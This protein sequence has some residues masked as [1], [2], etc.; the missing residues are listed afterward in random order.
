[1]EQ[2]RF[3][4]IMLG[5]N[6]W[7]T[8]LLLD[9][10]AKLTAEQFNRRFEIGLGSLHDTLRHIIG[11]MLR[12]ADRIAARTVQPSIEKTHPALTVAELLAFLDQAD[13]E[14]RVV[15]E[16]TTVAGLWNDPI[17]FSLPEGPVYR[18]SRAAAMMHVLS[19]GTYHRAQVVHMRKR[20]GLP[21]LGLDLDPIEWECSQTGQIIG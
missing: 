6:T 14:L 4:E 1:M 16:V 15:A 7:A 9:D 18:F 12:W 19:H 3:L 20:L 17:E 21:P 10:A 13:A 2:P 11:A 8:R 5:H